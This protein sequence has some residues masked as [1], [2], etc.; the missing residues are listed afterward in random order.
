MG[1][2]SQAALRRA[3]IGTCKDQE[4]TASISTA[5]SPPPACHPLPAACLF[6]LLGRPQGPH[7]AAIAALP[8]WPPR[9]SQCLPIA[10]HL[11]HAKQLAGLQGQKVQSLWG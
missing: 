4:P 6:K 9:P 2:A 5:A 7:C 1:G 10:L 3:C 11:P 8:A